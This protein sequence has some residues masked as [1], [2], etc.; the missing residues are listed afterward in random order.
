MGYLDHPLN[1]HEGNSVKEGPTRNLNSGTGNN[2]V[3]ILPSGEWPGIEL[4]EAAGFSM[5]GTIRSW[6]G[7]TQHACTRDSWQFWSFTTRGTAAGQEH[8]LYGPWDAVMTWT[9]PANTYRLRITFGN[10]WA[11]NLITDGQGNNVGVSGSTSLFV[12]GVRLV[13]TSQAA[14]MRTETFDV[15]PGE[16]IELRTAGES[17]VIQI[18]EWSAWQGSGQNDEPIPVPIAAPGAAVYSAL[19][20]EADSSSSVLQDQLV[21]REELAVR[22]FHVDATL[23]NNYPN[24]GHNCVGRGLQAYSF[25]GYKDTAGYYHGT[26][27]GWLSYLVPADGT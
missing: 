22:G 24:G 17:S 16:V 11:S 6:N 12:Q 27:G 4:M 3:A 7:L 14:D 1:N 20:G 9:V 15:Q 26:G 2:P 23:V 18:T 19:F 21:T 8:M 10:C 13:A 5:F 25:H